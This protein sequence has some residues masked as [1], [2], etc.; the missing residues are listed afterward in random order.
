MLLSHLLGCPGPGNGLVLLPKRASTVL[1][2]RIRELVSQSALELKNTERAVG[3]D[4]VRTL[5]SNSVVEHAFRYQNR[6]MFNLN[7]IT[8]AHR[9]SCCRVFDQSPRRD[10]VPAMASVEIAKWRWENR[11]ETNAGRQTKLAVFGMFGSAVRPG[12]RFGPRLFHAVD[13]P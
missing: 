6:V 9:A 4:N 10:T 2:Y 5:R 3:T 1:R 11:C 12:F 13:L 7:K 8:P